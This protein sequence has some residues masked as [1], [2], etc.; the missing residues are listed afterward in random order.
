MREK[1][2]QS[3]SWVTKKYDSKLLYISL[4]TLLVL[5][6][7]SFLPLF[8]INALIIKNSIVTLSGVVFFLIITL[9]ALVRGS[10]SVPDKLTS[11]ALLALVGSA[12][13]SSLFTAAP[14]L[15]LFGNLNGGP[16][17]LS[18]FSL[19]VIFYI[20]IQSL[21][22]FS[23]IVGLFLASATVYVVV[24]FHQVL[25]IIFGAS[26]LSFGFLNN[27][28]SSTIG[29]W[30]DFALLSLLIVVFSIICLEVG[31]FVNTA[32]WMTIIVGI[33]GF[34]GLF[35]TN[36]QWVWILTGVVLIMFA[37]Y[38]FSFGYWNTKKTSFEKG[39]T[40]PWYTLGAFAIVI[41]G[42]IFGNLIINTLS[43]VRPIYFTEIS[44]SAVSTVRAGFASFKQNPVLG[45]G[46]GTF[47][48]I[49][50]K[51]KD[52]SLS[53]TPSGSAE[54]NSGYGFIGTQMATTGILGILAWLLFSVLCIF[55]FIAVIR[56][57]SEDASDR[58]TRIAVMTGAFILT[59]V[60]LIHYPGIV[61]LVLWMIFLGGLWN[62][63]GS[64]QR[65][66]VFTDTP[67]KSFIGMSLVFVSILVA[68][69]SILVIVRQVG[70]IVVYSH[71]SKLFSQ[72]NE[73]RTRALQQLVKANQW[74]STDFYNRTLA[75]QVVLE[76]Q[77]LK[78]TDTN[79][80]DAL[81]KQVQQILGIG[82]GYAQASINANPNN[83]RNWITTGNIYQFF[84]ELKMDGALDR[85]REAYT[86]AQQLSPND[87]TLKLPLAYLAQIEQNPDMALQIVQDSL[88]QYPTSGA[89]LW[90][91]ERDINA[92]DFPAAEKNIIN[93]INSNPNNASTISEL[94]ILYFAQGKNE[95]ASIA[96]EQS[97]TLNRNQP[98]VV[99]LLGVIYELLG[100]T[101]QANQ[102]FDF[103]KKQLPEQAQNL[104]D[105]ARKQQQSIQ[106]PIPTDQLV[107]EIVPTTTIAPT[108]N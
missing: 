104:I 47:D 28:T 107:P 1:L 89:Y 10:F 3:V 94:G 40:I 108:N 73:Q 96:F 70:S 59:V 106:S 36:I 44:P 105:Q 16:T 45:S 68:G 102:V 63:S 76:A 97:L 50:N 33:L 25:R 27:L 31:K 81:A 69:F 19:F 51:T 67:K 53:G 71:S 54:F 65:D 88:K 57:D 86:K 95:N 8:G 7:L 42:I 29:S 84:A 2:S 103:L 87:S 93:A 74:W 91:Y 43:Q 98:G 82:L 37:L 34:F 61:I 78:P 72:G 15:A 46:I 30:S 85:A 21:S 22:S 79:N 11:W 9:Q 17:F 18:M 48:T 41:V 52:V 6:S 13:L 4:I 24:F 5:T 56:Q 92:R 75:N 100:K 14:R 38:V 60:S 77:N 64:V 39:R 23:R 49:W 90:L 83:Y 101:D 12:L 26:F 62:V 55:K 58:F 35:L 32:K 66:I 20:A 99:A 80:K